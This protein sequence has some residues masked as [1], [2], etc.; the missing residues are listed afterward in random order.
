MKSLIFYGGVLFSI[1]SL[2]FSQVTVEIDTNEDIP[3]D[4]R[5][6]FDCE[7][8]YAT[9]PS[10]FYCGFE[11]VDFPSEDL[12]GEV[13]F[14]TKCGT[15]CDIIYTV[16][17]D[18]T[19]IWFRFYQSA[20]TAEISLDDATHI[21]VTGEEWVEYSHM[22]ANSGIQEVRLRLDYFAAQYYTLLDKIVL[23]GDNDVT[24][25][26]QE[27]TTP[28][29][30]D[31]TT[32]TTED[33]T[34]PPTTEEP[35][36]PPTTEEPSTPPTTE[37]PT[38]PPTT[39]EPSTP[40]TTEEPTAPPTTE[41]PTAPTTTEEPTAP[42][43]TEEPSTPPTTEEP[44]APPTTE[45]PTAPPT[46]EEPTAPPTTEEPTSSPTQETTTTPTTTTN[47][48]T[49]SLPP[50][51]R[52]EI[53][54]REDIPNDEH[55]IL[56][57]SLGYSTI[58][59]GFNC[60]AGGVNMPQEDYNGE[61]GFWTKCGSR[62]V[63]KYIVQPQDIYYTVRL[64]QKNLDAEISYDGIIW[65]FIDG[66]KWVNATVNL[67]GTGIQE[68]NLRL[69]HFADDYFVLLDKIVVNGDL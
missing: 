9:T 16:Q 4:G 22:L 8:G 25:P 40:P 62:C 45:E 68:I 31:P 17:P 35:S 39:E 56:D 6:K 47:A 44:T 49:S 67:V 46:T 36:T 20:L 59:T 21:I 50:S 41:E 51:E 69:D 18:D 23:N 33:P 7:L 53:D 14:W 66:E 43:T 24:S 3:S 34:T 5:W 58:P 19:K 28:T 12:N 64:Y 52:I 60:V 15:T 1:F 27:P 26:T 57:C 37:E 61:V 63:I 54:I 2:V 29:T 30:E 10:D 32:P 42:P 55:W 65:S 48:P 38:A 11:G 13:G